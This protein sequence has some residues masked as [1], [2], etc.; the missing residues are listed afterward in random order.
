MQPFDPRLEN[1]VDQVV[2]IQLEQQH[3]VLAEV[4]RLI[5]GVHVL[6]GGAAKHGERQQHE[7]KRREQAT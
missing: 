2:G 3:R 1:G 5:G 7:A 4:Q 6:H